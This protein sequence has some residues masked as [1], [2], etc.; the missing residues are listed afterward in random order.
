[1][2]EHAGD[3]GGAGCAAAGAGIDGR[4]GTWATVVADRLLAEH[5]DALLKQEIG[6]LLV[7]G[8]LSS[9]WCDEITRRFLAFLAAHPEHHVFMR[10]NYV[11][12]VV[13]AMN[14]FMRPDSGSGPSRLDEYFARVPRDRAALRAIYAGGADPYELIRSF[15]SATGWKEL[16]ASEEA[17]PYHTDTLWGMVEPSFA[18]LHVDTYHR[19]TPCSL[20]RFPRRISCNTF[21]QRPQGGGQFRVHRH[22]QENGPLER[23]RPAFAEYDI[24]PGD[25]LVFDAGHYHEVLPVTGDRHRLF[26]HMA[27]V[28]DPG[29]REY[30]IIA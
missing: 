4:A 24:R 22:R 15:W 10:T 7:P 27:V 2:P 12:T 6:Y 13:M 3:L 11:D 5:V 17:G 28:L 18:P 23:A 25:L 8:L 21:V 1:L 26:S 20:S 16:P 29:S 19:E 30:S 14:V 9:E